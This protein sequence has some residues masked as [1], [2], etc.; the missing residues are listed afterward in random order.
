[1]IDSKMFVTHMMI[2]QNYKPFSLIPDESTIA[3]KMDN[4]T[5]FCQL[6][7]GVQLYPEFKDLMYELGKNMGYA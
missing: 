3:V 1:M 2:R 6:L 4:H 5:I 7:L